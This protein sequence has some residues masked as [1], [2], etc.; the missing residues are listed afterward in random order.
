MKKAIWAVA[1]KNGGKILS[2]S[3]TRRNARMVYR[4][5]K[6][7]LGE[8]VDM[9]VAEPYWCSTTMVDKIQH[10]IKREEGAWK[11]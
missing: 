3:T 5:Y 2:I 1:I 8:K 6:K 11:M 9:F 4:H 7:T 10:Q